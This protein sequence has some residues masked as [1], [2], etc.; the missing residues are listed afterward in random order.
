MNTHDTFYFP[1]ESI[2][3]FGG[4]SCKIGENGQ[5]LG[6]VGVRPSDNLMNCSLETGPPIGEMHLYCFLLDVQ[7]I[8]HEPYWRK[9]FGVVES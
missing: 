7:S 6:W 9:L 3:R 5:S 8:P 4:Y 2:I 1:S